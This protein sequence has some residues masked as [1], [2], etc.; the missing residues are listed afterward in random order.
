VTA[1]AHLWRLIAAA[2]LGLLALQAQADAVVVV[3]ARSPIKAL[4]PDEIVDVFLGRLTKLPDGTRATPVDQH[5]SSPVR[6]E[7][8]AS[9]ASM[10]PV[11]LKAYWAKLI[12]TG[13]GRPPRA[14][15]GDEEVLRIVRADPAAIGYMDRSL[16]DHTV[17]ILHP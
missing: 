6:T 7:I 17:R 4:T 14:V 16:A 5:E 8:Y 11:Q 3:A 2:A 9:L 12:F 1:R 10:S 15:A 13:R